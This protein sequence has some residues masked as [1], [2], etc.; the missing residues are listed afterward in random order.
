MNG[1]VGYVGRFFI[2]NSTNIPYT[3]GS[4]VVSL[5][6]LDTVYPGPTLTL[7]SVPPFLTLTREIMLSFKAPVSTGTRDLTSPTQYFPT[8]VSALRIDLRAN[9]GPSPINLPSNPER[10]TLHSIFISCSLL[11]WF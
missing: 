10:S 9:F 11:V 5:S 6:L 8:L 7:P 1:C 4:C 3:P 2:G